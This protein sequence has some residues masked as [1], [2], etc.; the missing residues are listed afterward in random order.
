MSTAQD[1]AKAI[2]S[3]TKN[4]SPAGHHDLF[5]ILV[6]AEAA[7][8]RSAGA[9][10]A[11]ASARMAKNRESAVTAVGDAGEAIVELYLAAAAAKRYQE[12]TGERL[13]LEAALLESVLV[14][15]RHG[16]DAVLHWDEKMARDPSTFL[17][18]S[19]VDLTILAPSG[20]AGATGVVAAIDWR[21]LDDIATKLSDWAGS[22][23]PE[24]GLMSSE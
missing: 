17:A 2:I 22:K 15:S 6:H 1:R 18:P 3:A 21:L 23:L 11:V 4:L 5:S 10:A 14:T 13:P 16:R 12:A 8:R 24:Q 9:Q 19:E 20:K 7:R